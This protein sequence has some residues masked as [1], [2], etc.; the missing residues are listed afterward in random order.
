MTNLCWKKDAGILIRFTPYYSYSSHF[1][2]LSE[3]MTVTHVCP[4]AKTRGSPS[5]SVKT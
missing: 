4:E 1:T 2:R 3:S 5:V